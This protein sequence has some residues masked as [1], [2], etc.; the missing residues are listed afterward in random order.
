[1]PPAPTLRANALT[2]AC[3][4]LLAACSEPATVHPAAPAANAAASAADTPP[5]APTVDAVQRYQD[6][7]RAHNHITAMAGRYRRSPEDLLAAYRQQ[8]LGQASLGRNPQPRLYL[9][10]AALQ[11][12]VADLSQAQQHTARDPAQQNL[13][14]QAADALQAARTLHDL[15]SELAR[16]IDDQAYRQDDFA[17]LKVRNDE[18]IRRWH[19]FNQA[20][21]RFSQAVAELE[22]DYRHSRLRQWQSA[23]DH[24]NSAREQSLLAAGAF[25]DTLADPQD[26]PQAETLSRAE[27]HILALQQALAAMEQAAAS[28]PADS[29]T[30]ALRHTHSHLQQLARQWPQFKSQPDTAAYNRMVT[31]YNLA[32]RY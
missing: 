14:H 32:I 3:I 22:T 2:L 21:Q 4:C 10:P 29:D 11:L 1:M 17:V 7:I 31:S 25:L 19:E 15:G 12:F 18:F 6:Y 9:D 28:A 23:G 20:Y 24:R 27:T 5:P 16:Y 8:N 26:W 13:H 30:A